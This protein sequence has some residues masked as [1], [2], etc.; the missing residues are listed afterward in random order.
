MKVLM[1]N[2]KYYMYL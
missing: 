2:S 1:G